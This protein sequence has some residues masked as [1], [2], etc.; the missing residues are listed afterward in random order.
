[1]AAADSIKPELIETKTEVTMSRE[2][3]LVALSATWEIA[4]LTRVL[5][6]AMPQHDDQSH[7]MVR[8]ISARIEDLNSAIMSALG[9]PDMKTERLRAEVERP[10]CAR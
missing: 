4:E 2:R 3:Q 5:R 9:E 7:F 8:G 6:E 1:M 10:S